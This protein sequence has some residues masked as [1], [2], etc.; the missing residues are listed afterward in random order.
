MKKLFVTGAVVAGLVG[1]VGLTACGNGS[2]SPAK[3]HASVKEVA[4]TPSMK[5][6][7]HTWYATVSVDWNE[8]VNDLTDVST[9]AS[10]Y[11]VS[12]VDEACLS[13]L[14]H[15]H[16]LQ[17]RAPYPGDPVTWNSSLNNMEN[18]FVACT[19]GDYNKSSTYLYKASDEIDTLTSNMNKYL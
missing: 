6:R 9:S 12:G 2:V 18:A 13:G 10:T 1:T 3:G 19:D 7:I 4:P 5:D 14:T 16:N 8:L 11:D 15:V 17:A